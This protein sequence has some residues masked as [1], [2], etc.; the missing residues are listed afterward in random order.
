MFSVAAEVA[1]PY[2]IHY[3]LAAASYAT[4]V[5]A[6]LSSAYGFPWKLILDR[7][8]G[9]V[10]DSA[11]QEGHCLVFPYSLLFTD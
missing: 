2:L 3:P 9:F 1:L 7:D 11:T 8:L 10:V 5:G 4:N 6:R